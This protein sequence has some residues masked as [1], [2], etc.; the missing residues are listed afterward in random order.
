MKYLME[1]EDP[2]LPAWQDRFGAKLYRALTKGSLTREQAAQE[3]F[4]EHGALSVE[5]IEALLCWFDDLAISKVPYLCK[6][7][8][9]YF[10]GLGTWRAHRAEVHGKIYD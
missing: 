5:E 6:E 10:N 9:T 1:G 8:D 3:I 7:C 4:H 2:K